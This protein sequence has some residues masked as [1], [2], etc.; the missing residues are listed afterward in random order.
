[1]QRPAIP[2]LANQNVGPHALASQDLWTVQVLW[3]FAERSGRAVDLV[4]GADFPRSGR[5]VFK[6]IV[7][8]TANQLCRRQ[9]GFDD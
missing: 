6:E 1:M 8:T 9:P 4:V 2:R 7:S 3:R 5:Y